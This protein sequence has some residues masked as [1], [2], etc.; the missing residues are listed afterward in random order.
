MPEE[1][2]GHNGMHGVV[3]GVV[4]QTGSIEHVTLAGAE[5]VERF[6]VPRQL[7]PTVGDFTGR[8]EYLAALD[9]MAARAA[10]EEG[11]GAVVITAVA[12][13]AGVGKTALAL[14]WAHR[15]QDGF[16]DGTLYADLR[17]YGPGE[18]ATP[19]EVLYRFLRALGVGP[20]SVPL[21]VEEQAALYRSLLAGSRVLVVLDNAGTSEQVRPLLPGGR[22]CLVVVTSRAALTGLLISPAATPMALDVMPEHESVDLLRRIIGS[23][24]AAAEPDDVARL[25]RACAGLPLALRIVG[26]RITSRPRLR[27]AD[28]VAEMT[29]DRLEVLS[30]SGAG[31]FGVTRVFDWSYRELTAEQARL[32]RRLGLHPGLDIGLHAVAAVAGV[33]VPSARRVLDALAEVH[34]VEP[35]GRARFRC[36]DL[37]RDYARDLADRLDRPQVRDHALAALFEW[38]A[39]NAVEA[40]RL[41]FPA[42][43]HRAPDSSG[44]LTTRPIPTTRADAVE[45]LEVERANLVAL[46]RAAGTTH[47]RSVVRLVHAT[48]TFL[49]HHARWNELFEVCV[50]GIGAARQSG[51]RA[52]EAWFLIRSGWARLQVSG[53]A[54]AADDL[55]AALILAREVEDPYLIAYALNDLGDIC[56][57]QGQYSE[58]MAH[59][60][61]ALPLSRGTDNGRQEAFVRTNCSRAL[62]GMGQYDHALHHAERALDLRRQSEDH[63]GAVFTLNQLAR[64]WLALGDH[65]RAIAQC[66]QALAIGPDH[67]YLPDLAAALDTLGVSA[68]HVGDAH[69]AMEC[70][71]RALEILDDFGDHRAADLRNRLRAVG[72]A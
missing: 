26:S 44:S 43:V 51:D 42:Y 54:Q 33:P 29:D 4:V 40:D 38:Y 18:P 35:A 32:F 7:P 68:L 3:N 64:V 8:A 59:L 27:V 13:I 67:A 23:P 63:E 60:G 62:A 1:L 49:Y 6:P 47:S 58:A 65:R 70:W 66:E 28:V 34:L 36:H 41:A 25:A 71:R 19:A 11:A 45:W 24:R 17:G 55:H 72:H 31:N 9:V 16:P 12:G 46:I 10:D 30:G 48:E 21:G 14:H 20:K 57:R 53:W 52:G 2:T 37:L 15:V 5:H 69:R 39:G 61:P 50:L 22:G 56:L